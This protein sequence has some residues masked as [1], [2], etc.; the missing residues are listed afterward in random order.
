MKLSLKARTSHPIEL[1]LYNT[2]ISR[3]SSSRQSQTRP[4][5]PY[6]PRWRHQPAFSPQYPARSSPERQLTHHQGFPGE[7]RS[8]LHQG[9]ASAIPRRRM[10]TSISRLIFSATHRHPHHQHGPEDISIHAHNLRKK[11][12]NGT[13]VQPFEDESAL[14]SRSVG[15]E[16]P[17]CTSTSCPRTRRPSTVDEPPITPA[18]SAELISCVRICPRPVRQDNNTHPKRD[19]EIFEQDWLA[20]R[21]STLA[22]P[23]QDRKP[24]RFRPE[25]QYHHQMAYKYPPLAG[26]YAHAPPDS[27]NAVRQRQQQAP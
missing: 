22:E 3:E 20:Q 16:C 9:K 15:L 13:A 1:H 2:L 5:H 19:I 23:A 25:G 7:I 21:H 27:K 18:A 24:G 8:L 11:A 14:S 4:K 17:E 10:T 6:T 26:Y 12:S